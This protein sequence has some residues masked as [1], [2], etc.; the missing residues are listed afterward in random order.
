MI[1]LYGDFGLGFVYLDN[2]RNSLGGVQFKFGPYATT[3]HIGGDPNNA[4]QEYLG[5]M[6]ELA[7]FSSENNDAQKTIVANYLSAKY[8]FALSTEDLYVQDDVANGNFDYEVAGIG[9]VD[10]TNEHIDAQGSGLV[11]I[12]NPGGLDDG[13]FLLWG[14]DNGI[15][16]AV[17]L[18][19]IPGTVE[20]R[21]DRVWRVSE[22]N[23]SGAAVDVGSLS[24]WWDLSELGSVDPTDLQL[25]IDTDDDGLFADESPIEGAANLGTGYYQ[26]SGVTGLQDGTRFTLATSDLTN[27]PLPVEL[28]DFSARV[29]D[30]QQ[31]ALEWTTATETNNDFF[32]VQR[33]KSGTEWETITEVSGA[34]TSANSNFYQVTD[35]V[36]YPGMSYYRLKQTDFDGQFT[37][38]STVAVQIH[39]E[40]DLELFPNPAGNSVTIVGEESVLQEWILYN[41]LG[42]DV[43]DQAPIQFREERKR[44]L[45]LH[46]LPGGLYLLKTNQQTHALIKL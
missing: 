2:T 42:Q 28:V 33:S 30:A 39:A 20:G 15:L 29:T 40:A 19:D 26:F 1:Q 34:G 5:Y 14:H 13:E 25:L 45:D 36:P 46:R 6:T 7:G 31:V 41:L 12:L 32:S 9:R 18:T 11:R 10:A 21:L 27:T 23:A 17:E 44:V 35:P 3:Y 16:A 37:F 4:D 8:G 24:V 22:V 43:T 38:S